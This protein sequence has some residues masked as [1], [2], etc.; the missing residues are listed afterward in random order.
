MGEPCEECGFD[1]DS[2][3]PADTTAASAR[4]PAAT[5]LR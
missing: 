4:S 3:S 2:L 1:A 5:A